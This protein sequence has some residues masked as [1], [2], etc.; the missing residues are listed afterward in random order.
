MRPKQ[1]CLDLLVSLLQLTAVHISKNKRYYAKWHSLQVFFWN[2]RT[3]IDNGKRLECR[4]AILAKELQR[5]NIDIAALSETRFAVENDAG[6]TIFWFG[7]SQKERHEAVDK[8]EQPVS[9]NDC[10]MTLRIPFTAGQY[11]T[12]FYHTL[13]FIVT[14]IPSAESLVILVDLNARIGSDTETWSPLGPHGVGRIN[15]NGLLL[16]QLCTE[17]NLVI[18]NIFSHQKNKA[19]WFYP[20]SKHGHVLDYIICRRGDLRNF[21]KVSVLRDANCDTDHLT[22]RAKLKISIRRKFVS[23]ESK[24]LSGLMSPS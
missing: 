15:S 8:I 6:Y 9:V 24:F 2:V 5:Y 4:T 7:K 1:S 18:T 10:I 17:L 3:H 16:L 12:S 22:V 21:C 23:T 20:Q 13:R 11:I 14:S 19:T